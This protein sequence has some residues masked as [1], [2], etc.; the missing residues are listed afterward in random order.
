[1]SNRWSLPNIPHKGWTIVSVYDIRD[2]GQSV[3]ETE[4]E[5]CMMCN[6]ERIRY[7]H[8]VTHP[9]VEEEF[10]VGCVCAEKMTND[11][12]TPKQ[13]EK[14]LRQKTAKRISWIKKSWQRTGMGNHTIIYEDHRLLIFKDQKTSKYKCKIGN[15]WGKKNFESIEQ[16]KN[17][18]FNGIDYL[19]QKNKW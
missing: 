10:S 3:D 17:A 11:Y 14:K 19:K 8:I 13:L 16:A 5:T 4:Y 1:M 7:V 12:V 15:V 9:E 2:D 6:N 18:I